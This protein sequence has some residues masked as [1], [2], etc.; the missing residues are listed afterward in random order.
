MSL[1][2]KE[3]KSFQRTIRMTDRVRFILESYE[4]NGMNEKFENLI[5][6]CNDK[7]P[8]VMEEVE[9]LNSEKKRLLKEIEEF[10]ELKYELNEI[11]YAVNEAK[12]SA[13][14]I[15]KKTTKRKNKK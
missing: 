8:E 15:L 7:V 5:L 14:L 1:S 2:T 11:E 13:M 4:G 10:K 9:R 12:E 3:K 6:D